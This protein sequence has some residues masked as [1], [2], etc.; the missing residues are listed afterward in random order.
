MRSVLGHW[1][2]EAGA[3]AKPGEPVLDVQVHGAYV[4]CV[5][6]ST[7]QVWLGGPRIKLI[8]WAEHNA[9]ELAQLGGNAKIAW[10]PDGQALAVLTQDS[11]VLFFQLVASSYL[12][13]SAT[14]AADEKW[15]SLRLR[16]RTA[17]GQRCGIG[18]C[19]VADGSA[20]ALGCGADASNGEHDGGLAI[21]GWSGR[22]LGVLCVVVSEPAPPPES[23]SMGDAGAPAAAAGSCWVE[24]GRDSSAASSEP[25]GASMHASASSSSAKPARPRPAVVVRRPSCESPD[26]GE[27]PEGGAAARAISHDDGASGAEALSALANLGLASP[28]VSPLV[29]RTAGAAPAEPE[30]L[31]ATP[32]AAKSAAAAVA[33]WK[34]VTS[35]SSCAALGILGV[36]GGPTSTALGAC[37]LVHGGPL[38][39]LMHEA[40]GVPP[41]DASADEPGD[42]GTAV[43]L[44]QRSAACTIALSARSHLAAVGCSSSEVRLFAIPRRTTPYASPY[45]SRAEPLRQLSA[46]PLFPS[47]SLLPWGLGEALTGGVDCLAFASDGMCLA[48]GFASRGAALFTTSG[49]LCALWPAAT[50]MG[51]AQLAGAALEGG[52]AALA[53]GLEDAQLF[54]VASPA[55][56]D[57]GRA[58]RGGGTDCLWLL[59]LLRVSGGIGAAAAAGERA[60]LLL[61]SDHVR[62][63]HVSEGPAPSSWRAMHAPSSYM[64]R[65]WPLRLAAL[66]PD[67]LHVAVAGERGVAVAQLRSQRWPAR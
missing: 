44:L 31:M 25:G 40:S 4:A 34:V 17:V 5:T 7:V 15:L 1:S 30:A 66:S 59:D 49:T 55:D 61:G 45:A 63:T 36:V 11:N 12:G 26:L 3:C 51:K 43:W 52:V 41:L 14:P 35:L 60:L 32:E 33:G 48:V 16:A 13:A 50:A 23:P 42:A 65:S 19:I 64:E 37:L 56:N 58:E 27:S 67:H 47:L 28:L 54:A 22:L 53:W 62:I 21:I 6:E 9:Q 2:L 57:R 20:I 10:Q 29:S 38:S 24:V 46:T 39:A 8:G 18:R